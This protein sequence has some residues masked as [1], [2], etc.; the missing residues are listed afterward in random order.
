MKSEY[1]IWKEQQD[2]LLNTLKAKKVL[3]LF[4]GG[5]DSS[6]SLY[7]LHAASEE[8]QFAFEVHACIFPKHR[9]TASE[10]GKIDSFWKDRGVDIQW[11]DVED[12]DDSLASASDPCISCQRT[13]K[14]HL[15]EGLRRKPVDLKNLVL[16]TAYTL[17]DLVSYSLEY[18]MGVSYTHP[19]V[20][21]AYSNHTRFVETGQRFYPILTM[22][23]GWTIYRPV[24]RYNKQD[25]VRI[26]QAASIPILSVPCRYSQSRPKRVLENYYESRQLH[27]DYDRIIAFAKECLGLPSVNEY[28]SVSDEH[29]LRTIF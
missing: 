17:W 10:V 28:S 12:S 21:Y 2:G 26:I 25:V 20:Q 27:F 1:S 9:Y 15:Y 5:K 22:Q 18:L 4:S 14:R 16:V 24:L 7:F 3:L 29:F 8:F 19:D 6:L 13:R 23:S 11:H